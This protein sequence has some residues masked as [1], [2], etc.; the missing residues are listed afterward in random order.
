MKQRMNSVVTNVVTNGVFIFWNLCVLSTGTLA[1]G[2]IKG[3]VIDFASKSPVVGANIYIP[4]LETGTA[5]GDEGKF[6]LRVPSPVNTVIEISF[7]GYEKKRIPVSVSNG[8]TIDLTIYLDPAALSLGEIKV[9]GDRV[10]Q[11]VFKSPSFVS[12]TSE[13][14][15]DKIDNKTTADVLREEPGVLV[16]KTTHAHGAPV[17]RGLIGKYV[18]LMYNGIRLN[19]PTFRFG[20]NQY[21]NTISAEA[22]SRIEVV[23]GPTSVLYGSDAIGGTVNLVSEHYESAGEQFTLIPAFSTGYSSADA[24]KYTSLALRGSK[25]YFTFSGTLSYKDF[26]N[27]K[28]GGGRVE[29]NPT[30]WTE[31]NGNATLFYEPNTISTYEFNYINVN[32]N[33]VPRY[34]KYETGEF[35]QWVYEPQDRQLYAFT[36]T[37]SP[38]YS[39]LH[40]VKVNMNYQNEHE[41]RAQKKTG[42]S[43][44]RFDDDKISTFGS[45]VQFSSIFR[46]THWLNWGAE[47]YRDKIK[48]SRTE[49]TDGVSLKDR[50][51]FPDNSKYD[52][53]G[54]Y[55]QEDYIRNEKLDIG[56]GLRYSYFQY[57]SPLEEFG[58]MVKDNFSDLT[59]SLS[60]SYNTTDY[61][62][63][64]GSVSRGFRAPNFNDTVVL[65]FSNSGVDAPS[66]NLVP[67]KSINIEA[68]MKLD[69]EVSEGGLFVYYNRMSELIDRR[70]GVYGGKSYFDENRNGIFDPGEAPIFQKFNVGTAEIYGTETYG[71]YR[72]D[73]FII[74]GH[75]FY[76]FGENITEKEPMSRIPP[77][78][79]KLSLQWY[80]RQNY[81]FETYARYAAKQD[82][83]SERDV[84]DSRIQD[85]G[86]PA[87]FTLNFR[88]MYQLDSH[89]I[90]LRFENVFDQ[91]YKEHGSGIYS[92]GRSF[93]VMYQF[94]P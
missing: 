45:Y 52:S 56:I 41:G 91:L 75:L 87:Y 15:F 81:W 58:G 33:D 59:G 10:R 64:I 74:S 84:L 42:S 67:E 22:L 43:T 13:E 20:A 34:D 86:T 79:G 31:I 35:E 93:S 7:I 62:N 14:E 16:Q 23:R 55:F 1:Q 83:L 46:T 37:L 65:K 36:Y 5:S 38:P 88:S 63:F 80:P 77:L 69:S 89:K 29:Q 54:V 19:K 12:I 90:V 57:E 39:W 28:P 44:L 17:I 9:V 71:S 68:G 76:T 73:P 32:Q 47:F 94:Q 53:F 8:G 51:A 66:P 70:F 82:R 6:E 25:Q 4:E 2:I 92:P 40:R 30:G 72:S 3:T 21:L 49:T 78:M 18:L 26:G 24:G 50:G 48:S 60:V 11:S 85:G 61:L 27:L